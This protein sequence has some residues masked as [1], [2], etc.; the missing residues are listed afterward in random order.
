MPFTFL[1]QLGAIHFPQKVKVYISSESPTLHV[2]FNPIW[3]WGKEKLYSWKFHS[4]KLFYWVK[5]YLTV[6]DR[7]EH[8]ESSQNFSL[9][10]SPSLSPAWMNK[11]V[12]FL[13]L[14]MISS[15]QYFG[16]YGMV[17]VISPFSSI[18][19]QEPPPKSNCQRE[20]REYDHNFGLMYSIRQSF[21]IF[22]QV[23]IEYKIHIFP[24]LLDW[25]NFK[26]CL[27]PPILHPWTCDWYII[28]AL[29]STEK[30]FRAIQHTY[31]YTIFPNS[32]LFWEFLIITVSPIWIR[33]NW[34]E[35]KRSQ[36]PIE[37]AGSQTMAV[38]DFP[39]I[40]PYQLRL[41]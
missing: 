23:L 37:G 5:E 17:L 35:G 22:L 41:P 2:P 15:K 13:R 25:T 29:I 28:F 8:W 30:R 11:S 12:S 9:F 6:S 19:G 24:K 38:Q 31:I 26:I 18:T 39:T 20:K 33:G 21:A 32:S 7:D 14:W 3:N 10:L 1:K 34:E 27:P 16:C 4:P 40:V 36:W